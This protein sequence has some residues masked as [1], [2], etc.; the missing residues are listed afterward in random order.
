MNSSPY[1]S[2][3]LQGRRS[4]KCDR[5]LNKLVTDGDRVLEL[6]AENRNN[7]DVIA[8]SKDG[9]TEGIPKRQEDTRHKSDSTI[10]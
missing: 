3:T 9:H 8:W 4:R 2:A 1:F 6:I 5:E 7:L 10:L